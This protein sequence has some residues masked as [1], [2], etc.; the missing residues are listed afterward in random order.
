VEAELSAIN[1]VASRGYGHMMI[2]KGI[3]TLGL[4]DVVTFALE[5]L[6]QVPKTWK[7]ARS[8]FSA[9][10]KSLEVMQSFVNYMEFRWQDPDD[11]WTKPGVVDLEDIPWRE[12]GA[13]RDFM[14]EKE[15]D[16]PDIRD[17]QLEDGEDVMESR[18]VE[19]SGE[20]GPRQEDGEDF[21]EERGRDGDLMNNPALEKYLME[22]MGIH[23]YLVDLD[24]SN[25]KFNWWE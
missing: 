14:K 7:N 23:D 3:N 16:T 19:N 5:G 15:R 21:N 17:A 11:W 2:E 12:F 6:Q 25:C 24:F 20:D 13:P 9:T 22:S 10:R 8:I 4:T 1:T 18:E